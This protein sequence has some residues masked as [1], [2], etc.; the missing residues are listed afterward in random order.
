MAIVVVSLFISSYSSADGSKANFHLLEGDASVPPTQ[1]TT[2]PATAH[3]YDASGGS[4]RS[5]SMPI[6]KALEKDWKND[7][8]KMASIK[9]TAKVKVKKLKKL[10][11]YDKEEFKKIYLSKRVPYLRK[12]FAGKQHLTR[13]QMISVLKKDIRDQWA[14]Y[15]KSKKVK[16][17]KARDALYDRA[18][19]EAKKLKQEMLV[20]KK[21]Y[22]EMY[23]C[24]SKK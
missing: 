10:Y 14:R 1:K 17:Y 24:K 8:S 2:T 21:E 12:K 13:A 9:S 15:K 16:Y 20:I 19:S 23:K 3:K 5:T 22:N 11:K 7:K 18:R 6:C 4:S